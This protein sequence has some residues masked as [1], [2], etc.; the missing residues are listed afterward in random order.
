MLMC[1]EHIKCAITISISIIFL[2]SVIVTS[3]FFTNDEIKRNTIEKATIKEKT[4]S[5]MYEENTS[6]QIIEQNETIEQNESSSTQ[7]IEESTTKITEDTNTSK[8]NSTKSSTSRSTS[9]TTRGNTT[10][11]Q[12]KTNTNSSTTENNS[13]KTQQIGISSEY[14]GLAT[15]GKIEIPKTGL[16]MPI[17]SKVTVKGMD[18]GP[19]FL[20][21][22]GKLNES[23]SS[24]IVGHN[25]NNIF[26]KNKNLNV[27]DKIYVTTLDGNRVEYTVYDKIRITA[28]DLSYMN[29]SSSTQ[30]A[31]STCTEDDNYRLVILAKK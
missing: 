1:N 19:C 6:N 30:I 25:Y 14:N 18:T 5:C 12:L 21:S 10:V 9:T 8:S 4:V 15:I 17:F 27:G 24:L 2:A 22:T 16:N 3:N 28:E 23:G 13:T 7:L 20:Y 26:G 11:N 31:I 29:K